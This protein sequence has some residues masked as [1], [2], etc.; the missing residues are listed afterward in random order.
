MPPP[1]WAGD[2]RYGTDVTARYGFVAFDLYGTLLDIAGL[3]PRLSQQLGRD[4]TALLAAWRT[5]QL[6]RSWELNRL[7][8]SVIIATHDLE[9]VVQLCTRA[10]ILDGGK[11]VAEG[12]PTNL[13]ADEPL[14][15]AHGL[16]RPH[17]LQHHHPH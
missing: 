7:G 4:A 16:E 14:M 10:V 3:A 2:L 15:L 9:L 12:P 8:T 1:R 13:L 6:E 5:A 17:I 11:I